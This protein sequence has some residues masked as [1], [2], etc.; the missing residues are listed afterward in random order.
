VLMP[1]NVAKQNVELTDPS[2]RKS[3]VSPISSEIA[4]PA[5]HQIGAAAPQLDLFAQN[6]TL[7]EYLEELDVDSISARQALQHLYTMTDLLTA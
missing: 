5:P 4:T 1:V 6:E 7:V 2:L 3:V